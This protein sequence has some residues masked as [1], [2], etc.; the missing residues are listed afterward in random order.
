[1]ARLEKRFESASVEWPTPDSVFQ[2]L[3]AEFH[4]TL[5]VC[6]NSDNTKCASFF[7]KEQNGLGQGWSGICWMN[8]PYGNEVPKWIKKAIGET[9][10][11]ATTVALIPARTNTEWWHKLVM[12]NAEVRFVRGRP[13]FGDS[14]HGLP[15][16]LAIL[17]FR[18]SKAVE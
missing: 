9:K 15:F 16:P 11:G 5:D 4:F 2:P 12:G 7:T 3:D 8:P 13:K 17:I 18:P 10:N 14:K 1:M 6:A